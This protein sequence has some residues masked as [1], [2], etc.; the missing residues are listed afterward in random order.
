[1]HVTLSLRQRLFVAYSLVVAAALGVVTLIATRQER[2]WLERRDADTLEHVAHYVLTELTQDRAWAA[3]GWSRAAIALGRTLTYRVTLVDARGRIVGDSVHPSRS[4]ESIDLA[5]APE[6]RGALAGH[7][8]HAI[9]R[10]PSDDVEYFFLAIPARRLSGVAAVRIGEPLVEIQRRN[11]ALLA[12]WVGASILTLA[13][14]M[15]VMFWLTGRHAARIADLERVAR[16]I[17]EG[18]LDIRATEQPAD[19]VGRLGH[20][21]N[22]MA[23]ELRERLDTIARARDDLEHMGRVRQ[24]FV[25]N[26]S[27]ELRTPLTAVLGYA[28]TL[29]DG[30][31][32]DPALREEF[33]RVIRDQALRLQ[34]LVNDL[35][36]LADLERPD[37]RLDL[38]RFDFAEMVNDQVNAFQERA[39]RA[40]LTLESRATEPIP[41][42][43]DHRRLEQVLVNLLDNALKYTETGGVTV[44]CGQNGAAV[45]CEVQDTGPGIAPDDQPRIFE[46]FYRADKARSHATGGT[47]LGLS[48]AKHLVA[49]H[50]GAISVRSRP[51]EGSVFRFEIP[52]RGGEVQSH[53]SLHAERRDQRV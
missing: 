7:V 41:I 32:D 24:D 2:T 20:A 39:R 22:R 9:R 16:R 12:F 11:N 30:G 38:T 46:R 49:L 25:A 44:R 36:A 42:M 3:V 21:M 47:G 27:H 51:G 40:G 31:M 4:G 13:L 43:A 17:G 53:G 29:L 26:V 28:E 6:I 34:S 14:F 52:R 19:E 33:V 8:A 37:V 35:L 5:A 18:E 10:A 23:G 50:Q 15:L 45:W 48:I 1:V